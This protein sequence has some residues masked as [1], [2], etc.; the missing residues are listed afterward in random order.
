MTYFTGLSVVEP[1]GSY[2]TSG[3]VTWR[4]SEYIKLQAGVGLRFEQA[5]GISHDQPCNPD[6]D[7]GADEAGP[8]HADLPGN[9]VHISGQPNPAYRRTINAVGRRFYVDE[10]MTYEV[11]AS[12]VV[13]F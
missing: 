1:Y 4:A 12:G 2:R 5:H 7:G 10:S 8:C 11:F 13:L 6:F 3:S 9:L